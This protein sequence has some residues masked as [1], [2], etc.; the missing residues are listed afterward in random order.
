MSESFVILLGLGLELNR[1]WPIK[2]QREWKII[3]TGGLHGDL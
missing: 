3:C 2:W 1:E